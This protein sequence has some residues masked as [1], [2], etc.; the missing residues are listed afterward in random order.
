MK[1]VEL[2][3]LTAGLIGIW[4]SANAADLHPVYKA[5]PAV[6]APV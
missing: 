5:P 1:R 6:A 2:S 3:A 4:T